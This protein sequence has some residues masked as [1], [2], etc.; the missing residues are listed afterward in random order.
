MAIFYQVGGVL[1]GNDELRA[2]ANAIRQ[3]QANVKSNEPA[4]LELMRGKLTASAMRPMAAALAAPIG[5]VPIGIGKPLTV[6]IRHVYTGDQAE[7]FWGRKGML[8]ASSMKSIA[9]YEGAPRAVNFLVRQVQN[10]T[11]F[12]QVAAPDA[13]T[14]LVC[15]SPA[16]TQDS[17]VITIEVAFE[18]FPDALFT[19][20]S[21]LF[22]S[23]AGIPIF[24]PASGYLTAAGIVTKLAGDI[25][26]SLFNGSSALKRNEEIT[27]VTPGSLE[28]VAQ[29][30][31][32]LPDGADDASLAQY[33]VNDQGILADRATKQTPYNGPVP[34]VVLSF[35]GRQHDEYKNFVPTA[36]SAALLEHF[37]NVNENGVQLLTPLVDAM[38]V[39]NDLRYR[40]SADT[41]KARLAAIADHDSQA[42]KDLL[43]EYNAN[44]ANIGNDLLKPPAASA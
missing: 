10:N 9:Q 32:L 43:A 2:K 16:L 24:A 40:T 12:R 21:Q 42:Y 41:L 13:G 37:F 8:V 7:G 33:E 6:M 17:S 18:G 29:F 36:A 44:V 30:A 25:G 1:V 35:D 15:Y 19:A 26:K 4:S 20:V 39:Y 22:T 38:K 3:F 5:L 27:F 23:A 28:G 14:P 34:Y 11:N 31:L